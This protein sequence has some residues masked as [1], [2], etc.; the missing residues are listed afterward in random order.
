MRI[1]GTHTMSCRNEFGYFPII[2]KYTWFQPGSKVSH[3]SSGAPVLNDEIEEG[4]KTQTQHVHLDHHILSIINVYHWL[5]VS[6]DE[7]WWCWLTMLVLTLVTTDCI[8][9]VT[10]C[11]WSSCHHGALLSLR[12]GPETTLWPHNNIAVHWTMNTHMRWLTGK[13]IDWIGWIIE[14]SLIVEYSNFS[15]NNI[16]LWW[17]ICR[18]VWLVLIISLFYNLFPFPLTCLK[19]L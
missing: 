6:C 16:D 13:W 15:E 10:M 1:T 7:A 4:N 12:S 17:I 11:Y 2:E 3:T 8:H 18:Y 5:D 9:C 14:L 19:F